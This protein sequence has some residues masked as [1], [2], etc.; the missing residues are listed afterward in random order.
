MKNWWWK[1]I[2][3]LGG[4]W[5]QTVVPKVY[6]GLQSSFVSLAWPWSGRLSPKGNQWLCWDP[7]LG[8]NVVRPQSSPPKYYPMPVPPW[9]WEESGKGGPWWLM[10]SVTSGVSRIPKELPYHG[11]WVS[12]SLGL[13]G[14]CLPFPSLPSPPSTY[15]RWPFTL[16]SGLIFKFFF[17]W[18]T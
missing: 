1:D 15:G 2:S 10:S 7:G 14:I 3:K 16:G 17:V 9:W 12:H 13:W 6:K 18:F 11:Q 8:P 4:K 5:S